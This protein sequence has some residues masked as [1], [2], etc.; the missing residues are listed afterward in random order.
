MNND[1]FQQALENISEPLIEEAAQ[2]YD[3]ARLKHRRMRR[4]L[5]IAAIAAVLALLLTAALWPDK[6]GNVNPYFSV[7][8]Y[9]NETDIIEL[10]T[11]GTRSSVSNIIP[12]MQLPDLNSNLDFGD[13][14]SNEP[15]FSIRIELN[16]QT[17]NYERMAVICNGKEIKQRLDGIFVAFIAN[18]GNSNSDD[19]KPTGL[20]L[21][22]TVEEATTVALVLYDDDDS[23][24]QR[25]VIQV[26]PIEE[27]FN[28]ALMENYI[29]PAY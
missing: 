18:A 28:V 2:V 4:L 1:I 6:D 21:G 29:K 17:K 3:H 27:G 19:L 9:A 25:Y 23:V 8:V 5:R 26:T 10:T 22:G 16:D 12:N 7:Y 14:E 13:N 11:D 15:R 24:L 20:S